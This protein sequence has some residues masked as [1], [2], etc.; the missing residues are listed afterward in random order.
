MKVDIFRCS[1]LA[2]LD[3]TLLRSDG[4][5]GGGNE[6]RA[7][8]TCLQG[9][10]VFGGPLDVQQNWVWEKKWGRRCDNKPTFD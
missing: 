7:P 9:T 10:R 4:A 1:G 3:Q 8:S 5:D 6:D 2:R